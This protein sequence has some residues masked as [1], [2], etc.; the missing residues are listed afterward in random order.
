L[1][2]IKG[3]SFDGLLLWMIGYRDG[4]GGGSEHICLPEGS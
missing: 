4:G 1:R 2:E 3:W